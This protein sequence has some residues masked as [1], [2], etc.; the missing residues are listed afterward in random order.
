MSIDIKRAMDKTNN[1]PDDELM[2]FIEE[3]RKLEEKFDFLLQPRSRCRQPKVHRTYCRIK[4][5]KSEERADNEVND[6][7]MNVEG[8]ES[9][10]N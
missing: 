1:E 5:D 10:A 3:Q 8:H 7:A 4:E 6:I 9:S 2:H